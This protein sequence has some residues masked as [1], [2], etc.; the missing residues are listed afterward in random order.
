MDTE[1][2]RT[3]KNLNWRWRPTKCIKF[4]KGYIDII[5]KK[6]PL[7][8]PGNEYFVL[9]GFEHVTKNQPIVAYNGAEGQFELT[10]TTKFQLLN[11]V[12]N[13]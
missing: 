1:A 5:T 10:V 7:G 12:S 2:L 8:I 11:T 9:P 6:Y 13:G 3:I 4:A